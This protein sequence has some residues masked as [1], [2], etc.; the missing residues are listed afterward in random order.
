VLRVAPAPGPAPSAPMQLEPLQAAASRPAPEAPPAAP[1]VPAA[2]EPVLAAPRIAR[3]AV[4]P[5]LA[6]P[7]IAQGAAEP[8][9]VSAAPEPTPSNLASPV[10]DVAP[11]TVRRAPRAW[12]V[13]PEPRRSRGSRRTPWIWAAVI[14]IAAVFGVGWLLGTGGTSTTDDPG[15]LARL[16]RAIGLGPPRF[17]AQIT[18]TPP[19]AWIAVDGKDAA[20]RT[21]AEVELAPGEHS[22]TLTLPDLGNA[23]TTVR[24]ERNAR[25]GVDVP[26]EGALEIEAADPN[27]PVTVALDGRAIGYAPVRMDSVL[28]GLHELQF[29]GPGMPA[30][31]QSIEVGV[32]RT[33]QIVAR[34]I[35]APSDGVI[36]VQASQSDE[37][38]T[39]PLAGAQVWVDGELK[40][41]TP[42]SLELPRGPHSLKLTWHGETAPVQVIDLPGGNQR[43][44][45]FSFGVDSSPTRIVLLGGVHPTSADQTSVVA[46]SV[47]GLAPQ[48]VREAWLHVRGP[49]DLW[50]R[51]AATVLSGGAGSVLVCVF[52]PGVF[53]AQGQTR[54]YL[55]AS[56]PQGDEYFTEMQT[57]SLAHAPASAASA[58]GAT[59]TLRRPAQR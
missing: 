42:T 37:Q 50:R 34:P 54:W 24:G 49:E 59:T 43:F 12:P 29:S 2:V 36:Q 7:P 45:S 30:W 58:S 11:P 21:P 3:A 16:V 13:A 52:P 9:Y 23:S 48:D 46:A 27:V 33:A 26:L 17:V 57:A 8:A 15:P 14:V 10:R 18:S 1:T 53:D 38:G 22:L 39:A 40:G 25:V 55:S 44:A 19:G 51:Y 20:R 47:D 35:S 5:A 28:P 6:P 31:A 41:V 56:T 32:H 4:E